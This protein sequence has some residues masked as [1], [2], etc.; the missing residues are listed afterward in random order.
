MHIIKL[1]YKNS[2]KQI[3][4]YYIYLFINIY[5]SFNPLNVKQI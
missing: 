1:S 3:D 4:F 5:I 2:K